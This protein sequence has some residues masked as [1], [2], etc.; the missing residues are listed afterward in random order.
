[1]ERYQANEKDGR[2]SLLGHASQKAWDARQVYGD[3]SPGM[4]FE[5]LLTLMQD[6]KFIRYPVQLVFDDRLLEKGE[7]AHPIPLDENDLK[8]GFVM[9]V[10]PAFEIDKEAVSLIVAYQLVIVNYGEIADRETAE[11]FGS[12][13]MGMDMESYYQKLCHYADLIAS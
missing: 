5:S 12:I 7:L 13:L 4:K 3:G 1:M 10:H 8:A 11:H 9:Y 6:R 2:E